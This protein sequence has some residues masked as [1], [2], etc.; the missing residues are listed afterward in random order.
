MTLTKYA[1]LLA[2]I[3]VAV[4]GAL[5]IVQPGLLTPLSDAG[6]PV[7]GGGA[8]SST[9]IERTPTSETTSEPGG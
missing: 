8:A 7:P 6:L 1:A 3:S 9:G 5:G 2:I 4:I